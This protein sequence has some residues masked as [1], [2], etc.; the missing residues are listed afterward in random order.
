M[1]RSSVIIRAGYESLLSTCE[2]IDLEFDIDFSIQSFRAVLSVST[3][4]EIIETRKGKLCFKKGV[5]W[6]C[7]YHLRMLA[8]SQG[9]RSKENM[10]VLGRSI[11]A[12]YEFPAKGFV[13]TYYDGQLKG[14]CMAFVHNTP[15]NETL[16]DG[17]VGGMYFDRL[18]LLARCGALTRV[19]VLK[20]EYEL[21]MNYID[22]NGFFTGKVI[23]KYALEW[24]PFFGFALEEDWR[25]RVRQQCDILFRVLMIMVNRENTI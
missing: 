14:P 15:I 25:T 2:E 22:E 8:F 9:W 4:D 19:D 21:L 23:H 18:E 11:A 16:I 1:P 24:S 3:P 20:R 5:L 17:T 6:P 13:Y 10:D 12:L 7:I